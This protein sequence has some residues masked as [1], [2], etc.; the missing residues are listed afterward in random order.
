[1]SIG[2]LGGYL[3]SGIVLIGILVSLVGVRQKKLSKERRDRGRLQATSTTGIDYAYEVKARA[4]AHNMAYHVENPETRF[5]VPDLP[6]EMDPDYLFSAGA[7]ENNPELTALG[8]I[9]RMLKPGG[10]K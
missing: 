5:K 7:T 9:A 1:M 8:E 10:E 2:N 4:A 3:S 6:K